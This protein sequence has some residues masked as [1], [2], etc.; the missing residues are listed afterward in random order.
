MHSL[1]KKYK[2]S[3]RDSNVDDRECKVLKMGYTEG[4]ENLGHG[5]CILLVSK[6][7]LWYQKRVI[8]SIPY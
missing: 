3:F 6:D 7:A 1:S 8:S 5:L 4:C 2:N